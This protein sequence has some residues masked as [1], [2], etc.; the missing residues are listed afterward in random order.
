MN[1][2][3][4]KSIIDNLEKNNSLSLGCIEF[5]PN[6]YLKIALLSLDY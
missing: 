5:A 4:A 2:K 1:K 6:I 3:R